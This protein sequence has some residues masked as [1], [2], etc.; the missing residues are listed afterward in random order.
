MRIV[1]TGSIAYDYLMVF[2]GRFRDHILPDKLDS[3]ALSFLVDTMTKQRG[4]VAPNI[5]YSLAL[6]GGQPAVLATAGQDF[7]EYRT[8]LESHG[9]DTSPIKIIPDLFTASFFA[10]TDQV[11]G[12]VALFYPGA[13]AQASQ[14]SFHDLSYRPDF[15]MISPDDPAAMA[16]HLRECV[17][18]GIPYAYDV[19]WQ[20]ARLGA[21]EI[22]EGVLGCRMLVVNDYEMG[23]ITDKTG[24]TETDSALKGKIVVVTRG[25][26]GAT[27]YDEAGCRYDIPPVPPQCV[28]DPTGAGDAF[29]GGLLRGMAA[30]WGWEIAGRVGALAATY[31]LEHTGT[32]NHRY[33]REEFIA[34]FRQHFDDDKMLDVLV[35]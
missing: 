26:N 14:V 28:A 3:L 4:G 22:Q 30:G 29:R 25:E 23:L 13:M 35:K 31:C 17:E 1:I 8:W 19:S 9:I 21:D 18:L 34:R 20:L 11:N 15:A 16:K 2:P 7:P 6:L 33:T 5:A 12:Q 32:Q 10:S 24:I 27:I